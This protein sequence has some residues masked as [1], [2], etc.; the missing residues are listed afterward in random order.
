MVTIATF[1]LCNLGAS[2]P[3][4]RLA[5]LGAIIIDE[6]GAPDIV[7]LQE[8][9][10]ESPAATTGPVCADAAYQ[11][12]I[13]AMSAV[14]GPQYAFREVPPLAHQ[15]GGM[16]CANIRVGL[17]FNP[18]RVTFPNRGHASPE[19]RVGIRF[20][21]R[22]PSLTLN[23]GRI[24][25]GHPAFAGDDRQHWMPSRKALAAEFS[26]EGQRLFVIVCH[27]KSMRSATR[28]EEDYAKQQRHAQASI[29]HGFAADLLACDPRAAVVVLGDLN[30]VPGSK[31]L[32]LL[33]GELFYNL[34]DDVPH[35]QCYTRR[36][37]EQL[38]ALDHILVSSALRRNATVRIAHI[39]SEPAPG[40]LEPA[41]DHD[42]VVATLPALDA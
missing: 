19:D 40:R 33:K 15:D 20:S 2:A 12:L 18:G 38:Q 4:E 35:G 36:H 27:F 42:P 9:M 22:Q 25:P 34:L 41:S 37:G 7:A 16:A 28:R 31:T 1:N 13:A 39:N 29:V 10:A 3:L 8:V 6:L 26:V 30:D 5:R 32:N 11:A 14:G 23:P 17:L 24:E 21:N